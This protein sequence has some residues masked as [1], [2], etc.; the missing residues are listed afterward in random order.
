MKK[1]KKLLFSTLAVLIITFFNS[2]KKN[3]YPPFFKENC[4]VISQDVS[5]QAEE[6]T[7][8]TRNYTYDKN[9]YVSSASMTVSFYA[10][11]NSRFTFTNTY[12]YIRDQKGRTKKIYFE[13]KFEQGSSLATIEVIY[14]NKGEKINQL[15]ESMYGSAF[16]VYNLKYNSMGLVS[17]YTSEYTSPENA[18]GNLKRFFEY[19]AMG[20]L[21]KNTLTDGAGNTI[22]Y[23]LY[24]NKG[25]TASNEAYLIEHGLLPVDLV[26]NNVFS[27]VDGGVGSVEN[28]YYMMDDNANLRTQSRLSSVSREA[29]RVGK[30][31]SMG[32][33]KPTTSGISLR[34]S[35]MQPVL[36]A[37]ITTE[38]VTLN[39]RGF[40]ES[41]MSSLF[42]INDGSSN[43]I[44]E[45]Y[46]FDCSGRGRK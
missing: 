17:E 15:V 23:S 43:K 45:I 24:E 19:N 40:P 27:I 22:K 38:S 1:M 6:E 20:Q 31:W 35:A 46:Q 4:K 3:D 7:N 13:Q 42:A 18:D 16:I 34:Q 39:R 29:R 21:T 2:C 5:N 28:L 44:N 37:T 41:R 36:V 14:D 30:F 8:Y 26:F 10:G 12:D 33:P 11:E 9:G 32:I 25:K